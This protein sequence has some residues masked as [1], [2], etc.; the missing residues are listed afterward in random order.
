MKQ[1]YIQKHVEVRPEPAGG[2]PTEKRGSGEKGFCERILQDEQ[3]KA[4]I[5]ERGSKKLY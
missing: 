2:K 4:V 3:R 1:Y 5:Q